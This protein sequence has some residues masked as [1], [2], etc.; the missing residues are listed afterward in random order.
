MNSDTK[1]ETLS[2]AN[3]PLWRDYLEL[4][5]PRVV[6]LIVF[7]AVIGM[8]MA[9]RELVDIEVLIF[10]TLGIWMAAS[11]AAVIN[12]LLDREADAQMTRTKHRPLIHG[13]VTVVQAYVFAFVLTA[14]S[15]VTL[16]LF[17]NVLTAVL[18]F[19]SIIGYAYIYTLFLKRATPQNIV[20]GGASGAAPP[21][22][23]WTAV[24]GVVEPGA[25]ILFLI[26]FV[27]TP[28]HFWA[29]AIYRKDEY[30]LVNIPMLPVTH[31]VE[32]TRFQ[33]LLYTILLVLV[34]LLP[35]M[36]NMSGYIYLVGAL[37]LDAIFLYYAIALRTSKDPELPMRM[38]W[39]SIIYLMALFFFLL[40]DHYISPLIG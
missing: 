14:V 2:P 6:G 37:I 34:T 24:T 28:P 10:G 19:I 36:I 11:G 16:V 20:I 40:L 12:Q 1:P 7:T 33:I 32:Y 31:G 5:K 21:L 39:F 17:T 23:G 26:I 13:R 22:L 29:L 38:F 27:W 9:R 18:T 30:A 25:L 15:M 8:F 4:T 3:T 35:F